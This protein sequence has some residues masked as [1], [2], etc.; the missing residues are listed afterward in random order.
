MEFSR[1]AA[2][3]LLV[4]A[5]GCATRTPAPPLIDY[6][7]ELT[8]VP[9]HSQT[10]DQC[11]PAA[12]A[13]ILQWSG[14]P[15]SPDTIREQIYVPGRRGSLQL[16]L[17]GAS[18]SAGRL[19]VRVH[20]S[21]EALVRLLERGRPV[22]VLQN[23]GVALIPV[24]HYAV[25]VGYLPESDQFVLRS[26]TDHRRLVSRT[27]FEQSW[28]RAD[29][30]GIALFDPAEAVSGVAMLD[31]LEE[32]AAFESLGRLDVAL[33]AYQRA[34]AAWPEAPLPG[35]ALGNVLLALGRL[36]S[37]VE[38]Y[39]RSLSI[40]P[41]NLVARNNLADTLAGLGCRE[42][43]LAVIDAAPG[44]A[45][46]DPLQAQLAKTRSE[47]QVAEGVPSNACP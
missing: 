18:R 3:L 6:P 1:A 13:T 15:V 21:P 11:G 33:K 38:A 30:W 9:F 7:V 47:I 37:A 29:H 44:T 5:A 17:L 8:G 34:V 23:L 27:R 25:V 12:L 4:L 28:R 20:E 26:G 10:T 32:A 16:E 40:D 22:L 19:P 31:Y 2:L 43:A 24:W 14:R 39:T 41:E 36:E 35:I 42:R 46:R 45:T